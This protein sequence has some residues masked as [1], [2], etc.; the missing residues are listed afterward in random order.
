MYI[1]LYSYMLIYVYLHKYILDITYIYFVYIKYTLNIFI[2]V[3]AKKFNI[4]KIHKA[5]FID[6]FICKHDTLKH[7][8]NLRTVLSH[9]IFVFSCIS[10]PCK[11]GALSR[12]LC[13]DM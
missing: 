7:C 13:K 12:F 3:K 10:A 2:S 4:S 11:S 8:F 6:V 9:I 5:S 1:Y